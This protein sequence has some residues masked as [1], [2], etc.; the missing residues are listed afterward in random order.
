[1]ADRLIPNYSVQDLNR[2][3]VNDFLKAKGYGIPEG[4]DNFEKKI[5]L[6]SA[7]RSSLQE[8]EIVKNKQEKK[9]TLFLVIVIVLMLVLMYYLMFEL[10]QPDYMLGVA[11]IGVVSLFGTK[12]VRSEL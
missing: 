10:Q 3:E 1:M 8:F 6:E 11:A 7:K 12:S 9:D 5:Y 2:P 4:S